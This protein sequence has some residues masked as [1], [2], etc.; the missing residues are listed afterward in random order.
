MAVHVGDI[1]I[2][3]TFDTGE[4]L[5]A[6]TVHQLFYRK[7]NG[8]TGEWVN[9][10]DGTK[11]TFTTTAATDLDVGGVWTIQAY[12]ESGTWKR[13]SDEDKFGVEANIA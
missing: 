6:A 4:D 8:T 11:L 9:T 3:I 7:P 12:V 5:T 2:V 13:H 1:G 10:I